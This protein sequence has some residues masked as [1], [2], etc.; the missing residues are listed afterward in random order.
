MRKIDK[1]TVRSTQYKE[2]L[3][4]L[5]RDKVKHPLDGNRPYYYDVIMNLL[6]CQKGVCAYTEMFLCNPDLL[7]E[8]K[9]ENG[10][11]KVDKSKKPE[12]FG[13]L[14]HF[15]PKLKK[16]KYWEWSNLFVIASKI[17]KRK[18]AKAVDDILK[19][20]SSQYDPLKLLEYNDKYHI[21][22]PHTGIRDKAKRKRIQRMIEVL[23]L[24]FDLVSRERRRFLKEVFKSREMGQPIEID[25]F[26]TACRMADAAREEG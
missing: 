4:K 13:E 9:W 7:H 15:D 10:K 23:H 24:N 1:T 6:L 2:W 11:Y 18:G 12:C 3:D 26:F 19:P 20:D 25:R 14:D 17:N 8:D 5:N 22:I 21:F 16:K